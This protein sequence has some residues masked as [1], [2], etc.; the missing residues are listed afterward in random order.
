MPAHRR[1]GTLS[2]AIP[3]S[4]HDTLTIDNLPG[5]HAAHRGTLLANASKRDF[6]L[7]SL[8]V[9][10]GA[11][12]SSP[13]FVLWQ[14]HLAQA[15]RR[16]GV[17][18][19]AAG[20][21]LSETKPENLETWL[22]APCA[23]GAPSQHRCR[24]C[25][26]SELRPPR[27]RCCCQGASPPPRLI[28]RQSRAMRLPAC[29]LGCGPPV[30]EGIG[31]Q[32]MT[33]SALCSLPN[34]LASDGERQHNGSM[35]PTQVAR[36]LLRLMKD[37]HTWWVICRHHARCVPLSIFCDRHSTRTCF[38]AVAV[39][40]LCACRR[41]AFAAVLAA[42][43]ARCTIRTSTCAM[44]GNIQNGTL[45]HHSPRLR[46]TSEEQQ[47]NADLVTKRSRRRRRCRA[48]A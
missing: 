13:S 2:W 4:P 11:G 27:R 41:A 16:I 42:E 20:A 44:P 14:S 9:T 46:A 17:G 40:A 28:R 22:F 1:C 25:C 7:A 6:R 24:R 36:G 12:T 31:I 29:P 15:G 47:L 30:L 35:V 38:L 33:C 5:C 32:S 3:E 18:V 8:A 26:C 43:E 21:Q 34:E 23:A 48:A 45:Q 39:A 19:A 10:S 37:A